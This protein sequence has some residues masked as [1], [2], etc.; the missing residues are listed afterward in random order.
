MNNHQ[1]KNQQLWT[2]VESIPSIFSILLFPAAK[3]FLYTKL[4]LVETNYILILELQNSSKIK[5]HGTVMEVEQN[6]EL[7]NTCVH[8]MCLN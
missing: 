6:S 1:N 5:F 2:R 7:N 4:F 8:L 3:Q